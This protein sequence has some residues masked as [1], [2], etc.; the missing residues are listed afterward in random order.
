MLESYRHLEK[1]IGR[2]KIAL[3][4]E[5]DAEAWNAVYDRLGRPENAEGYEIAVPEGL[6]RDSAFEE[7]MRGLF[8]KAGLT[9]MQVAALAEGLARLSGGGDGARRRGPDRTGRTGRG[10]PAQRMGRQL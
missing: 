2:D 10:I 1:L 5:G 9:K 3:P 4:K 6:E 7:Q 8:H